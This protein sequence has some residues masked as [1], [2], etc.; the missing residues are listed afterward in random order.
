ML[1]S[2]LQQKGRKKQKKGAQGNFRGG[3]YV[4]YLDCGD[5]FTAVRHM[6]EIIKC[7]T[8]HM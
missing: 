1:S 4:V 5:G 2:V 8:L 7:Y 3:G 6:P